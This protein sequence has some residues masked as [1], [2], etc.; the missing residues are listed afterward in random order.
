MQI[1]LKNYELIPVLEFLQGMELKAGDSRHRS[2][3]V[4]KVKEAVME[5]QSAQKELQKEYAVK[6]D[7]QIV[8]AEDGINAVIVPEK[9]PEY[10]AESS[11]LMA[12]EV[13]IH[14]GMFEQ[15]F[16]SLH[17]VLA[18]YTAVLSGV[19]AEI[20]DRLLTEFEQEEIDHA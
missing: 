17:A 6:Q 11:Q 16:K 8:M 12:E 20:Y 13:V 18:E 4:N 14:A 2:K 7:G 9:M 1:K 19:D 5:L 3:L 15:N 10:T